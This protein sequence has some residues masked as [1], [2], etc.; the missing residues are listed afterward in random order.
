[1]EFVSYACT[2]IQRTNDII[3]A[4]ENVSPMACVD[5]NDLKDHP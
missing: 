1:M 4:Y 3:P 5:G 2:A